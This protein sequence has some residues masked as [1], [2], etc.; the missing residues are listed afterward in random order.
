[1]AYFV[2]F[3]TGVSGV[4]GVSGDKGPTGDSGQYEQTN[5][6]RFTVLI[7]KYVAVLAK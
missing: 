7:V 3:C 5:T 1:M 2:C 4:S 6:R